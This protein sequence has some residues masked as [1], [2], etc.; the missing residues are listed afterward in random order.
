VY[1]GITVTLQ[2]C[3]VSFGVPQMP[4]KDRSFRRQLV[5]AVAVSQFVPAII[6]R[7]RHSRGIR[8]SDWWIKSAIA[9]PATSVW[10]RWA[11][12]KILMQTQ[13]NC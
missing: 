13:S 4:G 9:S 5:S 12:E 7:R 10:V 11:W 8:S 1:L 2:L 6:P 3:E